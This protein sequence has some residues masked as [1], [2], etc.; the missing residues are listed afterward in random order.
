[1]RSERAARHPCAR[2][3][4]AATGMRWKHRRALR[5]SSPGRLA[6]APGAKVSG[7]L[8]VRTSGSAGAQITH[9]AFSSRT[10]GRAVRNSRF[11]LIRIRA[12]PLDF[13]NAS[14]AASSGPVAS[15]YALRTSAREK[16]L[17]TISVFFLCMYLP[18]KSASEITLPLKCQIADK[19][20]DAAR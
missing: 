12:D 14:L 4:P 15:R 19:R 20:V 10:H 2:R 16:N 8:D 3:S 13:A 18:L 1:M 17:V 7:V 6:R 5:A 9:I 11:H